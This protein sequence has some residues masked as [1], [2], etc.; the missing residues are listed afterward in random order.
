MCTDG[1][2][3]KLEAV[4]LIAAGDVLVVDGAVRD[5]DGL[6]VAGL[7]RFAAGAHPGADRRTAADGGAR[8]RTGH[9]ITISART[10]WLTCVFLLARA[11]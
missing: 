3:F 8:W 9:R 7:P 6:D 11:A 2:A 4:D 10:Y 5:L 1:S